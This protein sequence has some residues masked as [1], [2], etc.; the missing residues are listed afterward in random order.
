MQVT[1]GLHMELYNVDR[2]L[3]LDPIA[4]NSASQRAAEGQEGGTEPEPAQ[5]AG[6]R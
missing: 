5:V 2:Q 3:M 4:G 1:T 6:Q